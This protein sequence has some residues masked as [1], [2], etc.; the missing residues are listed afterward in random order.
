ML[1]PCRPDALAMGALLAPLRPRPGAMVRGLAAASFA[2]LCGIA[3]WRGDLHHSRCWTQTIGFTR[4]AGLNA[5]LLTLTNG[6]GIV[7]T[8]C[9]T[10]VRRLFGK[11]S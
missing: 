6:H 1:T 11:F 3:W 2:A 4:T 8:V 7:A 10:R 9:R 5:C